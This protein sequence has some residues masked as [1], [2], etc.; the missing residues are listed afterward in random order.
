M[1][2]GALQR[3]KERER[4]RERGEMSLKKY[5]PCFLFYLESVK[6]YVLFNKIIGQKNGVLF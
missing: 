1:Q 2:R 3:Q 5:L 4:E 6:K